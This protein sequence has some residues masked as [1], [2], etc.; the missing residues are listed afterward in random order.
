MIDIKAILDE[1]GVDYKK[2]GKNVG[3]N[4]WNVDCPYC[5]ADKHLG[6]NVKNGRVFCWVCE[7]VDAKTIVNG[8]EKN[9]SLIDVLSEITGERWID[10]KRVLDDNGWEEYYPKMK[11][12]DSPET[13][14]KFPDGWYEFGSPGSEKAEEYLSKRGFGQ[15]II[16]KYNLVIAPSTGYYANRIIIPVFFEEKIVAFTG[17]DYTGRQNRYKHSTVKNSSKRMSELLYNYDTARNFSHLYLLE[18]P[19]DVWKM[20]DDSVAVFRS[21][22][23]TE[24]RRLLINLRL[25]SI[26][27]IFDP[28]A[29]MRAYM[30]AEDLRPF[31]SKVKVIRLEGIRDVGDMSRDEVLE[32]E[33]K[34][35]YF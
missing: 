30:A 1:F 29:T 18:G 3:S 5:G 34:S 20:G 16:D 12:N 8:E 25:N 33:I 15:D 27:I 9:P 4:D 21:H 19:T 6:I 24:Q 7:F 22:L 11:S 2:S 10:I 31:I 26:T 32:H 23:S 13:V 35:R 14:C 17:R 28:L